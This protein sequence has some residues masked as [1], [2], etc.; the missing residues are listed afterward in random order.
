MFTQ[1]CAVVQEASSPNLAIPPGLQRS[2]FSAGWKSWQFREEERLWNLRRERR[3][4]TGI[5]VSGYGDQGVALPRL[6]R[7][8][9]FVRQQAHD[10]ELSSEEFQAI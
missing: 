4:R 8:C 3:R 7:R 9:P 6:A 10:Q 1:L 5:R 2:R